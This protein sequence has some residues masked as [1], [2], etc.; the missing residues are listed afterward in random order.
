[1]AETVLL[2]FEEG[3]ATVTLNRPE[4]MNALD[5]EMA[6]ALPGAIEHAAYS[7]AVR[8]IVL[9]G[10]GANFMVGGDIRV[11]AEHLGHGTQDDL[12]DAVRQFQRAAKLLRRAPK[13]VL[14]KVRGAVAGGGMSLVLACD[15]VAAAADTTFTAAYAGIG[16]SPDGGMTYHLPRLVGQRVALEIAMLSEPLDAARALELGLVNWV[17]PEPELDEVAARTAARL[18]KG[19]TRALARTKALVSQSFGRE[20]SDQLEA[21]LESFVNCFAGSP[22]FAEGVRAFVEKRRPAFRGK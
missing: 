12:V 21:E 17:V 15:L 7:S 2:S 8:A 16:A 4:V 1:M 11:F 20:M 18:A 22:D 14:A 9:T 5:I 6:R 13:P 10:S 3:V 19:P